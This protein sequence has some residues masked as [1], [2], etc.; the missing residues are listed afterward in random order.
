MT[1]QGSVTRCR[2]SFR[3]YAASRGR[4]WPCTYPRPE[5]A[6]FLDELRAL[7][8]SNRNYRLIAAMAMPA[9]LEGMGVSEND[10]RSEEFYGY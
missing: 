2:T 3:A 8:Q 6:A 9:M 1:T 4:S 5:D 10:M 7:E